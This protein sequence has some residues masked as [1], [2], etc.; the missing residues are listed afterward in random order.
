MESYSA[1]TKIPQIGEAERNKEKHTIAN[2]Y[3]K[4]AKSLKEKQTNPVG[5]LH[6][7]RPLITKDCP[8]LQ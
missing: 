8:S 7:H 4:E 3:P 6:M 1:T 2:R 5:S